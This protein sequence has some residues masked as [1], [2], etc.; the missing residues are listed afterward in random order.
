MDTGAG[1]SIRTAKS[2]TTYLWLYVKQ[3]HLQPSQKTADPSF[4]SQ[5]T[6]RRFVVVDVAPI[7]NIGLVVA[8]VVV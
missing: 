2:H 1:V 6:S 4:L 7:K 8:A 5:H 3:F